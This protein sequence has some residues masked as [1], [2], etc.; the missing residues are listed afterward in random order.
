MCAAQVLKPYVESIFNLLSLIGSD[1]NRSE[2]L[3]RAA[4]GVIG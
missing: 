2:S 3:M 1:A 4:M